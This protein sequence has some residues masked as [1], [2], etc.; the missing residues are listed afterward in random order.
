VSKKDKKY[1]NF[2]YTNNL[3]CFITS[4]SQ[5]SNKHLSKKTSREQKLKTNPTELTSNQP[6]DNQNPLLTLRVPRKYK[7]RVT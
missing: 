2:D 1:V 7:G 4:S 6:K 5:L 3:Q